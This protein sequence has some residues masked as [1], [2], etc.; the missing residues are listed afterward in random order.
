MKFT[1][2]GKRET[3]S[4]VIIGCN[5]NGIELARHFL[6][7]RIQTTLVD[8][9]AQAFYQLSSDFPAKLVIGDATDDQVIKAARFNDA[10]TIFIATA[11]DNHNILIS[12]ILRQ[13]LDPT[14]HIIATLNDP[15]RVKAYAALK[16]EHY[17]PEIALNKSIINEITR[18]MET[19]KS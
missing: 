12:Q 2:K 11:H 19:I 13:K 17:S 7:H 16:I 8:P 10:N 14:C 4:I 15:K 18:Q 5:S 3:P 1:S 9:S 6:A